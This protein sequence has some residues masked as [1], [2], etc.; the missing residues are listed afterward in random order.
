ME[1]KIECYLVRFIGKQR[2]SK[3]A[4]LASKL[5]VQCIDSE[6]SNEKFG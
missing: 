6:I 2:I 4:V 3:W 5:K 1:K